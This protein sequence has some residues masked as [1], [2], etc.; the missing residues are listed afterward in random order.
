MLILVIEVEQLAGRQVG[1]SC[2]SRKTNSGPGKGAAVGEGRLGAALGIWNSASR[3][4]PF[5]VGRG[6]PSFLRSPFPGLA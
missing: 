3:G 4:P 1:T 2:Y 5:A 6:P